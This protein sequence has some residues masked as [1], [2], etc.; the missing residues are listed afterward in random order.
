MDYKIKQET[1]FSVCCMELHRLRE[2]FQQRNYQYSKEEAAAW[3]IIIENLADLAAAASLRGKVP[4]HRATLMVKLAEDM[5]RQL[6][7]N[8][9]I[10]K[11][12]P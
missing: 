1:L 5:C 4:K 11:H 8:A 6:K 3:K 12:E 2:T 10:S 9:H 7:Q